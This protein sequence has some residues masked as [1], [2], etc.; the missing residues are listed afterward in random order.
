MSKEQFQFQGAPGAAP[1]L[2]GARPDRLA[3]A[4][5]AGRAPFFSEVTA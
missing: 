1:I 2:T 3:G 4:S 5:M